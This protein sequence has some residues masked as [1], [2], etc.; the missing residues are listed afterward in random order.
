M[1][2]SARGASSRWLYF[3]EVCDLHMEPQLVLIWI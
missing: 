2:V 3:L 1:H